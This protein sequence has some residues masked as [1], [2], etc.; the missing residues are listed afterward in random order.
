MEVVEAI[1]L[2]VIQGVTEF[3]PVSSTGHLI[4]VPWI[5]GWAEQGLTFDVALH[6]GTLFAVLWY[7]RKDWVAFAKAG[8]RL[9]QGHRNEPDARMVMLIAAATIPGA[10]AGLLAEDFVETYLRSPLVV[11]LTLI[12]LALVLIAAERYGRREKH[13]DGISWRDALVVGLAQTLALVPGVS[14]SGVTITAGLFR[15]MHRHTAAHFSFFLSAPIIWGAGA[16]NTFDLFSNGVTGGQIAILGIGILTSAFV[17][18][19]AIAFLLR[20][21]TTHTTYVFIYYRIALGIVVLLAISLG[22]R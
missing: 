7:F 10:L 18:Y 17:G 4:L 22:F 2:G 13:L 14:R 8:V 6:I 9:L 15:G 3:L 5:L 20:Y 11:A 21:L 19:L 12:A 1:V 16:K